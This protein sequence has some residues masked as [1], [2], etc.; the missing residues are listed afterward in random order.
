[1]VGIFW[2]LIIWACCTRIA[3]GIDDEARR[4]R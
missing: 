4:G 3:Q 1:M 2:I